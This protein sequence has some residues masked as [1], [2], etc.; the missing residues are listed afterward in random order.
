MSASQSQSIASRFV[1]SFVAV[2]D[3]F[4]DDFLNRV[5][6]YQERRLNYKQ[7]KRFDG[8]KNFLEINKIKK[9]VTPVGFKDFWKNFLPI[10]YAT[11]MCIHT[12]SWSF[13]TSFGKV[14]VNLSIWQSRDEGPE[15][16][17]YVF[18]FCYFFRKLKVAKNFSGKFCFIDPQL[19]QYF[20][21]MIGK[22]SFPILN[23]N[24]AF[25]CI[26]VG[27]KTWQFVW[28]NS[29]TCS[30]KTRIFLSKRNMKE[31]FQ[32]KFVKNL[33][34]K[35]DRTEQFA[36]A[37]QFFQ[38]IMLGCV[39]DYSTIDKTYAKLLFN[40]SN[41]INNFYISDRYVLSSG[42]PLLPYEIR[43]DILDMAGQ[44]K[45][46]YNFKVCQLAINNRKIRVNSSEVRYQEDI[47][48]YETEV[49]TWE[50]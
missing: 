6:Q 44:Y 13:G 23:P 40:Y 11:L 12:K 26:P 28:R 14:D 45:R 48:D 7:K 47:Q 18:N 46:Y 43:Y 21:Y 29:Q 3:Q 33:S 32:K 37:G 20:I 38:N 4:H 35:L 17:R 1:N 16:H 8:Q 24:V 10:F 9:V 41:I 39:V 36:Y 5:N 30:W 22:T 19:V 15:K 49:R 31:Y 2:H 27:D 25:D 42:R 34:W 50:L